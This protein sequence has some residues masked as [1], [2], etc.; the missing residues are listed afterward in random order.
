MITP[1]YGV[2]TME[3]ITPELISRMASR[4]YNETPQPHGLPTG[5]TLPE[6][7]SAPTSAA[8]MPEHMGG[9]PVSVGSMPQVAPVPGFASLLN[10][11]SI[12]SFTEVG[13][14]PGIHNLPS[15]SPLSSQSY[16]T[17]T[18]PEGAAIP[19]FASSPP[20]SSDSASGLSGFVRSIRQTNYSGRQSCLDPSR[21]RGRERQT[22]SQLVPLNGARP[23]DVPAIREDFPILRQKINGKPLIWFDNAATTQKPQSV[24][25]AVSSFY[26][27]D[28]SNIHRGAHS[29]AAR[30]TDAYEK[31]R[32]KVQSFL[33]AASIKEIVFVRGTTEGINL[34]A[35]TFGQ[36]FLQPGDEIV[37]S[38][39]E[40]H[41]QIVPWQMVAKEKGAILRVIPVNDRGEIMMEEY[42]RILGPRTKVVALTQ[43]SNSLGT[44]LP[45]EEMTQ[46]AKRYGARVIID[47]AQS[48]A[49]IPVNIQKMGADFFVFSGHKIFAPTG[50]GAVYIKEELHDL[51]PPWQGGGNMI[52]NVTFEETSY[53]EVPARLE[54]GTPS[55]ADAV[56]LGAALDYVSRIGLPN[57]AAYEHEL[58]QYA[59]EGLSPINGLRLIGTAREK[60]SV[61]SFVLANRSTEDV[62]RHL[63]QEGI[64]VRS[65][66]HCSQPSLRRFGVESTVRPSLTF[67]NTRG[68]IDRLVEAVKRIQALP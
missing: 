9:I 46:M 5:G 67:Y 11:A 12:P 35:R 1:S 66:H 55:I 6:P 26:E 16:S 13:S 43:A 4:I 62:G 54:A 63:N 23:L 3:E 32:E 61:L 48:V 28:Y 25:D 44:I 15:A 37:L 33:G 50:I 14:I 49:H 10:V 47:G 38:T 57:I 64:A 45:V 40:H 58:L 52:R 65:G 56:G 51:L 18:I 31:A 53:A 27:N 19:G 42:Q 8:A 21:D 29:L 60:V 39:L 30:A 34:V 59:T 22:T 36:K 17:P 7:P 2:A 68:E 24:I 41:A 20:A